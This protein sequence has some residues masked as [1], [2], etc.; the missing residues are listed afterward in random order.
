[1][2]FAS[3]QQFIVLC[4][5][6]FSFPV[7]AGNRHR[8][9]I[10]LYPRDLREEHKALFSLTVEE[11]AFESNNVNAHCEAIRSLIRSSVWCCR[12]S[13]IRDCKNRNRSRTTPVSQER[14]TYCVLSISH[15]GCKDP[16]RFRLAARN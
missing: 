10:F 9:L 11:T 7:T 8:Q 15:G 16:K 13:Q 12:K 3:V 14:K 4:K 2:N 1:M 6:L 5:T